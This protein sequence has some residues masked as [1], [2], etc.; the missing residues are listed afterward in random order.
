VINTNHIVKVLYLLL[1]AS[2]SVHETITKTTTKQNPTTYYDHLN[3]LLGVCLVVVVVVVVVI[4][5]NTK[6]DQYMYMLHGHMG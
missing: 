2:A 3:G 6:M 5:S 1:C 4:V